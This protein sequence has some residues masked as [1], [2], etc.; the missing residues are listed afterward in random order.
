M[1]KKLSVF[2]LFTMAL[3][4]GCDEDYTVKSEKLEKIDFK[5]I[6]TYAWLPSN[7]SITVSIDK[8]Q[9][10]NIIVS[11]IDM[12][13]LQRS[14]SLDTVKPDILVRYSIM[15]VNQNALVSTPIYENRTTV[16]YGIGY[17]G[18]GGG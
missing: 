5:K 15:L 10:H 1:K 7:D 17:G 2:V 12:Q 13:L 8:F 6:R 14:M 11:N 3:F 16:N 9:L 18:Y 4:L